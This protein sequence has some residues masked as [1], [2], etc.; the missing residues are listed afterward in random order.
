MKNLKG[1]DVTHEN[2]LKSGKI[3]FLNDGYERAN[4]RKICKDAG[5]TTGAFYRH[6]ED[7]EALFVALVEP[8]AK[9]ILDLY[10]KFEEESFRSIDEK[11]IK[12]LAEINIDGS[13]ETAIYI[14]R[15]KDIFEL[16]VYKAYG[17]KYDN[18]IEKLVKMEDLNRNKI[19]KIVLKD[20]YKYI[21][22]SE[23]SMHLL[24]HA[25][26]NALCEIIMHSDNIEE[27]KQNS[28]I[29]AR[30]FRE[31]WKKLQGF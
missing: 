28:E 8:L 22:I 7:K 12:D 30:F 2:I 23:K 4:L 27:V 26:I 29:V 13:I 21:N 15:K 5:V 9:E 10:T 14:F 20:N 17:T 11:H 24:N 3:N 19:S 6:F 1:F 25:Y 31:G 18:F 16:L